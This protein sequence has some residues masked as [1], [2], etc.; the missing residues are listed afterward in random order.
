MKRSRFAAVPGVVLVL[1]ARLTAAQSLP[2]PSVFVDPFDLGTGAAPA[3]NV[4][5]AG[6]PG[7]LWSLNDNP[8]GLA[9]VKQATAGFSHLAWTLQQSASF[10]GVAFPNGAALGAAYVDQGSVDEEDAGGLTGN[11]VSGS[12]V[13]LIGGYGFRLPFQPDFAFG[14]SAQAVQRSLAGRHSTWTAANLGVQWDVA[15][16]LATLGAVL[17]NLGSSSRFTAN[18]SDEPQP[19]TMR[20]GLS[21]RIPPGLIPQGSIELGVDV[22]KVRDRDAGV[23]VGGEI[24]FANT[25]AAR[26]GWIGDA[27]TGAFTAGVGFRNSSFQMD[28]G[29]RDMDALGLTHRVSVSMGFIE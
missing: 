3:V 21:L 9:N 29:F 23:D 25:L 6:A 26:A 17:Q 10:V 20:G 14:V 12:D 11:V 7:S 5:V 22:H 19:T 16:G 18:G 28:Y 13:G 8:A 4:A 24:W 1:C 2:S 15:P 27:D